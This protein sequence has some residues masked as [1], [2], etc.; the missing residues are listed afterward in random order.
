ML[1]RKRQ[2]ED[3]GGGDGSGEGGGGDGGGGDGGGGEG[4]GEDGATGYLSPGWQPWMFPQI[5]RPNVYFLRLFAHIKQWETRRI[6]P[7]D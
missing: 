1:Y 6:C 7:Y 3:G 2:S 4:Q 5:S